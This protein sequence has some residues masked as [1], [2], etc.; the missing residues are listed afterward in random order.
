MDNYQLLKIIDNEIY[1]CNL[2]NDLVEKF[3]NDRTVYLGSN[4]DIVLIGEA[5]ANNGWR[6]SHMLWK[7]VNGK[8]LPSGKVLQKLFDFIGKS[9]FDITFIEAVK[10]YPIKRNNLKICSKNCK[11]FMMRQLEILKP[12]LIITLG[13]APTRS[14][15]DFKFDKFS[16]VVGN[17]YKVNDFSVLPIYHPSPISPKS[18][19]ENVPIFNKIKDMD[20]IKGE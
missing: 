19:K 16:E 5:P 9:I 3:L 4:N 12:K 7:D 6:K 8:V 13:D 15:L 20:I 17:I 18:Y 1:N 2:C 11:C 10:C 14:I